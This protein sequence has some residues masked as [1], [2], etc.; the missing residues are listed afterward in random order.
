MVEEISRGGC[1]SDVDGG[2]DEGGSG[3]MAGGR[4]L[5]GS[6]PRPDA[7]IQ[8]A[9]AMSSGC[10]ML[11]GRDPFPFASARDRFFLPSGEGK[12]RE[13]HKGKGKHRAPPPPTDQP[14]HPI[15]VSQY[16]S[17]GPLSIFHFTATTAASFYCT[18]GSL[19]L[20]AYTTLF[21]L[22]LFLGGSL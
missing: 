17:P 13:G 4:L 16:D 20:P 19:I 18:T 6:S 22:S 7:C 5:A 21:L 14:S 10:P 1:S 9:V 2:G 12:G 8:K 3:A 15:S 11:P